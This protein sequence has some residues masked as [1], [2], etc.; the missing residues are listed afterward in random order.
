VLGYVLTRLL[1][2][3]VVVLLVAT[4]V[5]LLLHLAPGDP[6]ALLVG[7]APMTRDQ[8][9][10]VRRFWG[11][12]QPLPVQYATWIGNL[13]RGDF[14][15][16]VGFGGR[17]VGR[18]LGETLPN[19]VE[20]NVLALTGAVLVAIPVG[21]VAAARQHS[22][23]DAGLMIAATLGSSVPS[24]WLGLMAIV[25]FALGLGWL[26]PFGRA[27][28]K[29]LVLPVLV[30]AS[31]QIA[32]LA[33]L[34]RAAVLEGLGQDHVATARA[35]GLPDRSVLLRHVARAA[36]LPL[37]TVVGYRVAFLLSG[38]VLV[39]TVFGWPGM[40]R[41]LIQAIGQRDYAV[42]QAIVVVGALMVVVTNLLCDLAYA[43][44]DPRVR[45]R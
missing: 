24:F 20:L 15:E 5:F 32:L 3:L 21:I 30:L 9:Q 19:T 37:I 23:F 33:R 28:W 35:K 8:L 43:A 41:L 44:V 6:V 18:L 13:L 42:V 25:V 17:P 29:S 12:D 26:P 31:D 4:L 27:D 16:S 22:A 2:G 1:H 36:L 38:T 10:Q 39:E 45:S 14:G 40:G 34:T 11:L 7:E